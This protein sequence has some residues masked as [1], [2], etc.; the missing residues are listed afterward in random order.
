[1]G[2][3]SGNGNVTTF[4]TNAFSSAASAIVAMP[5]AVLSGVG[6]AASSILNAANGVLGTVAG[7]TALT[8][9]AATIAGVPSA[10]TGFMNPAGNSAAPAASAASS[11]AASFAQ[12]AAGL[13]GLTAAQC[14]TDKF[15]ANGAKKEFYNWLWDTNETTKNTYYN[16]T[17]FAI[18]GGVVTLIIG[19]ARGWFSKKKG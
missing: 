18:V 15:K 19:F 5:T 6:G 2:L 14:P 3:F 4:L 13:A 16:F 1:M 11:A 17:A 12:T 7:S 10:L 9:V 8:Q